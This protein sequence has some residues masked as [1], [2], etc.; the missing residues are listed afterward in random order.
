MFVQLRS[1]RATWGC[2]ADAGHQ[3]EG[4]G[5]SLVVH[6]T[7]DQMLHA[8]VVADP[9]HSPVEDLEAEES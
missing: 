7:F 2:T 4:V 3:E 5:Y 6:H 9:G 1:G 8:M